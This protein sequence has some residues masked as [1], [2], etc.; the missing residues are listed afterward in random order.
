MH[1]ELRN[2]TRSTWEGQAWRKMEK[3]Q[4]PILSRANIDVFG[5]TDI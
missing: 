5:E 4:G 1:A 2:T 3:V